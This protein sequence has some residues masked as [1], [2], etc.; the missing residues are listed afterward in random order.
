MLLR[1]YQN[2]MQ[3]SKGNLLLEVNNLNRQ[4]FEYKKNYEKYV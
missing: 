1:R 4:H 2:W 3:F